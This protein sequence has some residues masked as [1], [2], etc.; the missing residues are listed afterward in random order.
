V[1][2]RRQPGRLS[3]RRAH[4]AA[5]AARDLGAGATHPREGIFEAAQASLILCQRGIDHE[6]WFSSD[7][8]PA[9]PLSLTRAEADALPSWSPAIRV[10]GYQPSIMPLL[11]AAHV[12]CLPTYREGLPIALADALERVLSDDALAD[13]L[14]RSAHAQFMRRCTRTA[15]LAQ[16]LP[17]YHSLGLR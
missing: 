2:L 7:I 15:T 13:R 8:D 10:L 17:A 3:V 5:P 6:L 14:R 4:A 9:N 16:A 1:G 12:V 11:E